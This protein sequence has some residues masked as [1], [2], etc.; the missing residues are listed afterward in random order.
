MLVD[1]KDHEEEKQRTEMGSREDPACMCE[2]IP[3]CIDGGLEDFCINQ[4]GQVSR[5]VLVLTEVT[6]EQRLEGVEGIGKRFFT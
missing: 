2:C 6:L 4:C 3:V 1:D 5:A